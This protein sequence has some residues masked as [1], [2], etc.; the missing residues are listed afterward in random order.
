LEIPLEILLPVEA[1]RPRN[2]GLGVEGRVL[3]HLDDTDRVVVEMVL[4]PLG[5]DQYVLRIVSHDGPPRGANP[6]QLYGV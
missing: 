2:M 4:E 6:Y 3:V 5:V 1:D